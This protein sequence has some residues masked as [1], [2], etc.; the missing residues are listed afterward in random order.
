MK[1]VLLLLAIGVKEAAGLVVVVIVGLLKSL[2]T[3]V[4]ICFRPKL[5]FPLFDDSLLALEIVFVITIGFVIFEFVLKDFREF[6][7]AT[8]EVEFEGDCCDKTL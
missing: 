1:K 8:A 4:I 6:N 5:L 7:W 3:D 2:L